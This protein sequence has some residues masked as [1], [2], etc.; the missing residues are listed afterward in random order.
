MVYQFLPGDVLYSA[1]IGR[2]LVIQHLKHEHANHP[3]VKS[4]TA[5][6]P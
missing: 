2:G 3:E 6:R 4:L 1:G 5:T